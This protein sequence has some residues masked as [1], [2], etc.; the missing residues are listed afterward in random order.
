MS[1]IGNYIHYK[2]NNYLSYGT[3]RKGTKNVG[4]SP[5][6]YIQEVRQDML[7]KIHN[8]STTMRLKDIETEYNIYRDAL[9]NQ[10]DIKDKDLM[11]IIFELLGEKHELDP[12][13]F[14]LDL[15][16]GTLDISNIQKQ[17]QKVKQLR[18]ESETKN[19]RI[20]VSKTGTI[21]DR[22]ETARKQLEAWDKGSKKEKQK[23][24]KIL[25]NIE[26]EVKAAAEG[27]NKEIYRIKKENPD[28]QLP[29]LKESILTREQARNF[30]SEINKAMSAVRFGGVTTLKGDFEEYLAMAIEL[31]QRGIALTKSNEAIKEA[32]K[33]FIDIYGGGRKNTPDTPDFI[34]INKQI[35]NELAEIGNYTFRHKITDD[36]G[37]EQYTYGYKISSSQQK[38]DAVFTFEGKPYGLSIK[39]YDLKKGHP[40]GLVSGAPLL[41][42]LI[43]YENDS[44]NYANHFLNILAYHPDSGSE[45]WSILRQQANYTLAI[46][47]LY[48]ALSGQWTGKK[49]GF[50]EIL[51]VKDSGSKGGVKMYDV[52]ALVE[53]ISKKATDIYNLIEITPYERFTSL[54]LDNTFVNAGDNR[55]AAISRRLT[56]LLADAHKKKISLSIPVDFLT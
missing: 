19:K 34:S 31:Q 6:K 25:E 35:A 49:D 40:I 48:S 46:H 47:I 2:A 5:I 20:V 7:K 51:V 24:E 36:K 53:K 28:L 38:M 52:A 17:G 4:K 45:M 14:E 1:A 18:K 50:A 22:L 33:E 8:N 42:F 13:S 56:Q 39:N 15:D 21:L 11:N 37:Q 29:Y 26:K 10:K 3:H 43:G 12:E 54:E 44:I 23:I 16:T 32:F 27:I 30:I 9:V 41:N 55:G